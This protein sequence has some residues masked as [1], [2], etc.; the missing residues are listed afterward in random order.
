MALVDGLVLAEDQAIVSVEF[1]ARVWIRLAHLFRLIGEERCLHR[2][3]NQLLIRV[4][5][6]EI[7][8]MVDQL[9]ALSLQTKFNLICHQQVRPE[10]VINIIKV[11]KVRPEHYLKIQ[12]LERQ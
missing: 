11:D 2:L 10:R 3:R 4:I 8:P 7:V 6:N 9:V 1:G 5:P 12:V